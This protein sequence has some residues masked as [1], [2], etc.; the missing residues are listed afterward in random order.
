MN[1][2]KFLVEFDESLKTYKSLNIPI[3][4]IQIDTEE[5]EENNDWYCDDCERSFQDGESCNC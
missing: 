4:T 5:E 3:P 1:K 2:K